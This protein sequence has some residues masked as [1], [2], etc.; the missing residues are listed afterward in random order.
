MTESSKIVDDSGS[1]AETVTTV[2]AF[3]ER[4][5]LAAAGG[6]SLTATWHAPGP[7]R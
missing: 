4:P 1:L 7:W 5:L 6:S 3:A 2:A